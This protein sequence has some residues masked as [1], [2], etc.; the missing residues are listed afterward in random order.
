MKTGR[1]IVERWLYDQLNAIAPIYRAPAPNNAAYPFLATQIISGTD[2]RATGSP[3]VAEKILVDVSA[4]D[5]G[6]SAKEANRIASEVLQAIDSVQS[7]NVDGGT[8]IQCKRVGLNSVSNVIEGAQT[9]QRDGA[10]YEILVVID[11][12]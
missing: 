3:V 9:Y 12:S 6:D 5:K 7:V 11:R 4:W 1:Q 2:I 8:I 10:R